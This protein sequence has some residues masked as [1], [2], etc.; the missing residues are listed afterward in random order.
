MQAYYFLKQ[1]AYILQITYN[2]H[3]KREYYGVCE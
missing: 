1:I 2:K 3:K